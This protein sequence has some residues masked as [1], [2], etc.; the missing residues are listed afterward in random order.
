MKNSIKGN[1]NI[2]ANRDV[3]VYQTIVSNN[4]SELGVIN[5]IFD[6]VLNV[7][8][9]KENEENIKALSS[10]KLIHLK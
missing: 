1:K 10:D 5:D 6:Y 9:V 4:E 2:L 8:K 7:F 3:N